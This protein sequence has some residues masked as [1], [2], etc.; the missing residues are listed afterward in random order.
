M[1]AT[2]VTPDRIPRAQQAAAAAGLDALLI[3]PGPDLRYLT[4]YD[5][6]ALERL[7]CLVVPAAGAPVLVV[8]ELERPAAVDSPAGRLDLEIVG[9]AETADPVAL[10]AARL[11]RP[12]RIGLA[13]QM[14]A[15]KV[16]RFRAALPEA[17]QV[18]ASTVLAGLRMRKTPEEVEALA[19]AAA[20]IDVVHAQVPA[21]LRAGRTEREVGRDIA[22]AI[23]ESGHE[24]VDFVIV[25]AGPHAASP[26]HE[27]SDRRLAPGDAVVVDI[28]GS[29]AGYCSDATRTYVLGEPSAQLTRLYDV[30][31]RAQQAARDAVRPGVSAQDVDRAARAVIGEAGYGER[32][33]HRTGHGIGV[34]THE[35]PYIVEGST[36]PLEPGMTFS[37]EPGIYL[38][39]RYG[40]RIED[41]VAVTESMPGSGGVRVLNHASRALVVVGE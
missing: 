7:T 33:I 12:R 13:D 35:E 15:E 4:G 26:H 10:V 24:T 29:R 36:R 5:A 37:V 8:P 17:E 30:L 3:T 21:L 2:L 25:G 23:L 11:N 27:V 6:T 14:W 22:A 31:A 19:A 18:P 20:A 1:P 32:F 34:E 28:G 38:P 40:A 41:I 16:L 9:W 39:D